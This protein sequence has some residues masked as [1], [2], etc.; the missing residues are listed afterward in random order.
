MFSQNDHTGKV[1]F[2]L[3]FANKQM[4]M[5]NNLD[6][7]SYHDSEYKPKFPYKLTKKYIILKYLQNFCNI[8]KNAKFANVM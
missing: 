5:C 2:F 3:M 6:I 8:Y 7:R 4:L 1:F